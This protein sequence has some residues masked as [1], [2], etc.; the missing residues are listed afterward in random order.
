MNVLCS[1][2]KETLSNY[3]PPAPAL[4]GRVWE[5]VNKALK[6]VKRRPQKWRRL[7]IRVR[8]CR[9]CVLMDFVVSSTLCGSMRV[10]TGWGGN[11]LELGH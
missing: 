5:S 6:L 8:L 1:T 3:R 11:T 10:V 4:L 7:S 9:G 2:L